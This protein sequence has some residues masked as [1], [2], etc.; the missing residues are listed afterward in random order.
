MAS[1]SQDPRPS[2]EEQNQLRRS[3]KKHKRSDDESPAP[4][5]DSQV[6][7]EE[8]ITEQTDWTPASFAAT[9]QGK[10]SRLE[11][12]TGEGEDDLMDDMSMADIIQPDMEEFDPDI[13][14]VVDIPW[15]HYRQCW[16]PWRRALVIKVLGKS[17]SYRILQDRLPRLW[18]LELGCELVDIDKGYVV[19]RFYSQADYF[20]VLNGGP[21]MVM[22]N[23]LTITKW[24][25]NFSLIDNVIARTLVWVRF[26]GLLLEMFE[27]QTLMWM[28]NSVGKA[29][30][31]DI[32]TSSAVRGKYAKVCVE[33]ALNRPLK[34]NVM[35]YGKR[36]AVEY[37]GLTRICFTCGQF[38]HRSATCPRNQPTVVASESLEARN[39]DTTQQHS[40][41]ATPYDPW[42]MPAH[43][44]R[45]QEQQQKRMQ[46]RAKISEANRALN[47]QIEREL[48][49]GQNRG[50][51]VT[52]GTK[53]NDDNTAQLDARDP[54][55]KKAATSVTT[56]DTD[57]MGGKSKFAILRNISEDDDVRNS[58]ET[59]KKAIRDLP[60]P[61]TNQGPAHDKRPVQGANSKT[62]AAG[63]STGPKPQTPP[64]HSNKGPAHKKG[65]Q[66]S[67]NKSGP[68]TVI[69]DS[70]LNMLNQ[71][72]P[73]KP[74][75]AWPARQLHLKA[76]GG[77][78]T[79]GDTQSADHAIQLESGPSEAT[80][81]QQ[82]GDTM[83]AVSLGQNATV[84]T[85]ADRGK[86][87]MEVTDGP[88]S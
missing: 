43:V 45:R 58:L 78:T 11:F 57:Q 27:E 64:A 19:A 60:G 73:P 46:Q 10:P 70:R 35:V 21:W 38:G 14:P 83:H 47:A 54:Q 63:S 34:P 69:G 74:N 33:V 25:P 56:A 55:Q 86:I 3:I 5:D 4:V 15:D 9:L 42:M 24:R 30:K 72:L 79:L 39:C 68:L 8:M 65:S 48:H 26:P 53:V 31:V 80:T 37:K 84:S 49:S 40:T 36:Y 85:G 59:L 44:R 51:D 76:N 16:K 7:S 1:L 22:G 66:G 67:S 50:P 13:C 2:L 20:K 6:D 71:G 12:Y 82:T 32:C 28:G 17:I 77:Q 75:G 52:G 41:N 23:Y 87:P 61:S 62:R 29:I 81:T 18:Q 88:S